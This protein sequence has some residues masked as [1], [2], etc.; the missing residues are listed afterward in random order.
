[1]LAKALR[2]YVCRAVGAG[3]DDSTELAAAPPIVNA[4]LVT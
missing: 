2:P 3:M 4:V 1:M